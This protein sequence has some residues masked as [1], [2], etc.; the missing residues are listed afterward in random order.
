M[1]FFLKKYNDAYGKKIPGMTR[2]AQTAMLQHSWPGNVREL[3]NVISSACITATGEFIDLA[4]LPEQLQR[5]G[6]GLTGGEDWR[7][8]SL[9]EVCAQ[10]IQRVLEVCKGNRLRAAQI[11]G[12]G[13]TSLYRYLKRDGVEHKS[14]PHGSLA[15]PPH[16]AQTH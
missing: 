9:D 6:S 16:S 8:L 3:E 4:D 15:R 2:R 1:Q 7:P 12:I 10:H 11:L 5:R 14:G 13:R